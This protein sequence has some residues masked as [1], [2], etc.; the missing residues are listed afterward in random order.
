MIGLMS[1]IMTETLGSTSDTVYH[2]RIAQ[3]FRGYLPVVVDIETGGFNASTD[4]LLEI[5]AI[6]LRQDEQ[7]QLHPA[8]TWCEQ[9]EPFAGANLETTSLAFTGIDP[10]N[11][12]RGAISEKIALTRLFQTI[13]RAMQAS[14]CKK[15]ILVGHNASFDLG[16]INAAVAR[17]RQKR[18]PFHPFSTL[19]TVTLAALQY[20]QT[21]LARASKIAGIAWD[22]TQAHGALYDAEKTA[23]LFCH[24]INQWQNNGMPKPWLAANQDG[25]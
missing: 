8:E 19:D 25:T 6:P 15:A 16:F 18:N 3:R 20:G 22:A 23:E 17:N 5:A 9:I 11:P 7:G 10:S 1:L 14:G 4:A 21:V 2:P 13:R 12:L 24:M